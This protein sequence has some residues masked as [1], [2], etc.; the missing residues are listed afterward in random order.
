MTKVMHLGLWCWIY[1]GDNDYQFPNDLADIVRANVIADKVL[2]RV[3]A[4]PDDPNGP[5]VIQYRKPDKDADRSTE[6]I[7]FEIFDQWP[8]DGVVVCFADSHSELIADQNRFE[9]LI[10]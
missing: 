7:L 3:L 4:S 6:V 1:A 5:P 2:K 9:E 10:K 8:K